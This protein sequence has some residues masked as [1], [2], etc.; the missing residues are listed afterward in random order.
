MG[1]VSTALIAGRSL[2]RGAAAPA[3]RVALVVRLAFSGDA[4]RLVRDVLRNRG[5]RAGPG[6][7]AERDGGDEG[8]VDA[9]V[10]AIADGRPVLAGAVVVGGDRGGAEVRAL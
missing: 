8:G 10:H 1:S 9:G 4:E 6:V 5:V 2:V 3:V 7:V